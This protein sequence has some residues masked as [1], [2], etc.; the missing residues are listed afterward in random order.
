MSGYDLAPSA[1]ADLLEIFRY[2]KR[3]W[4]SVQAQHYREESDLA[5]QQLSLNPEAGRRCEEIAPGVRSYPV[6][7]HVA[8]YVPRKSTILLLRIL[9]PRMNIHGAFKRGG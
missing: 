8:F 6:A 3:R 9:H 2:T 4:G 5:I 7:Q 1:A